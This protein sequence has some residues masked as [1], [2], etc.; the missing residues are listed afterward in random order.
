MKRNISLSQEPRQQYAY[1]FMD[2]PDRETLGILGTL[3]NRW[4]RMPPLSRAM[5]V[6]TGRILQG[7]SMPAMLTR[8]EPGDTD[9]MVGLIGGTSRGSLSPDM[10]FAAT[11]LEGVSLASPAIFGYTLANIPLA[12]AANHYHLTGPVYAVIDTVAPLAAAVREAER[13]VRIQPAFP[14]ILA[15]AFDDDPGNDRE[16]RLS[17]TFTIVYKNA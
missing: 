8:Y 12:E 16:E 5:V 14:F 17:L 3:P 9:R 2:T 7:C 13:L 1:A 4:G 6:E 11:L 15:C 10:D